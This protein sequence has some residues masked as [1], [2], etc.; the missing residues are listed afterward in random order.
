MG[1][2]RIR[3]LEQQCLWFGFQH[4]RQHLLGVTA[5]QVTYVNAHGTGTRKNDP[6]ETR[7]IKAVFK[8]VIDDIPASSTK[9]QIGHLIGA[10]GAVEL[11]AVVF[12]LQEGILP[13]TINL[14][15]PD[16]ACDLDCVAL[17]PRPAK[18]R[19]ALSNSFGFGGQNAA[20]V[21]GA[22]QC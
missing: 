14:D 13:A 16:P 2:A 21:V 8:E 18:V 3:R 17:T 11:A 20:I 15:D 5:D 10:A 9:S 4:H 22:P 7:A 6:A 1:V 12:A 19:V